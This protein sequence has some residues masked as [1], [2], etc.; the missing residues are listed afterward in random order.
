MLLQYYMGLCEGQHAVTFNMGS[1][2]LALGGVFA[3]CI[4][5]IAP[6]SCIPSKGK[7][8]DF[9]FKVLWKTPS[10]TLKKI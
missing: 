4:C 9:A 3:L 7:D 8:D 2:S 1:S 10:V 5:Y 6:F